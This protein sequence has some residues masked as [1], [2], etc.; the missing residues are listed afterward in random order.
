MCAREPT[1]SVRGK[2]EAVTVSKLNSPGKTVP[3][4]KR[5]KEATVLIAGAEGSGSKGTS[6][7]DLPDEKLALQLHLAMNGSQRISRSSSASWAA[8][9]GKGKGQKVVVSATNANGDQ[10]LCVTN[11]MYELEDDLSGAEMGDNSDAE[12]DTLLDPSVTVVLAL[13]CKG[14]QSQERMRG[15]RK[16]PPGTNHNDVVDRYK[17][18]YTKRNSSKN[19]KVISTG[20]KTMPDGKDMDRDD[21]GKA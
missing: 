6:D 2:G 10:G 4:S 20:S 16:G 18:K 17:K 8:S 12:H 9:G 11:M 15:K 5:A 14:K 1:S 7:P 21:G 3:A 19:A 13:E